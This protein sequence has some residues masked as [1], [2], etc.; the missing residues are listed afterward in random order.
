MI[1]Y[2]I[3]VNNNDLITYYEI[4]TFIMDLLNYQAMII[5]TIALVT[6]KLLQSALNG[7][8]ILWF[9]PWPYNTPIP[10]TSPDSKNEESINNEKD[11]L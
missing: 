5:N 11:T 4:L 2:G 3:Y 8:A 6:L 1:T 9:L 7:N 10:D